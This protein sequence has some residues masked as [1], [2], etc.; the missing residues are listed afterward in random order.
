MQ[1]KDLAAGTVR[2]VPGDLAM[3]FFILAE[4]AV[5]GL[6]FA[7]YGVVRAR[8]PALFAAGQAGLSR[9]SALGNTLLLIA[10]SGTM[11]A[12]VQDFAAGRSRR[13]TRWLLAT[14]LCGGGFLLLK[15]AEFGGHLAAGITLSSNDFWMFYLALAGFHYL[16]VVLG[17]VIIAAVYRAARQGRYDAANHAGVETAAAYWHMVDL[18]W[19]VLFA[20]VY[21]AR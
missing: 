5:F 4:L 1:T 7:I 20:L 18:V 8:Q 9:L 21:V 17:M 19:L 12:A 11:A 15:G 13:G 6:F 10:G 3:W 16:H 14:L 2:T